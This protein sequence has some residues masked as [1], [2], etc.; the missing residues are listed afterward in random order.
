MNKKMKD[1]KIITEYQDE[2]INKPVPF[3]TPLK[4]QFR[5]VE[6]EMVFRLAVY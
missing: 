1:I 3:E 5:T 6:S 4:Y 2:Q